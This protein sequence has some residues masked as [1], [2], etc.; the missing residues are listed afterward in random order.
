M[1]KVFSQTY[2]IFK[3]FCVKEYKARECKEVM[4]LIEQ[5]IVYHFDGNGISVVT[6]NS[7]G[8]PKRFGK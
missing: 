1:F 4:V 3:N 7:F 2:N 5:N 8:F 6:R